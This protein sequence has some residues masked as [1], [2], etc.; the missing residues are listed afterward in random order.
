MICSKKSRAVGTQY[1]GFFILRTYG[2]RWM[3]NR[4]STHILSLTGH[5]C[6]NLICTLSHFRFK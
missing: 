3:G 4:F 1:V 2:T 6:D 5:R